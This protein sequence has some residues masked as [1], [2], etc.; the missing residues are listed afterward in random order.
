MGRR[1]TEGPIVVRDDLHAERQGERRTAEQLVAGETGAE[2]VVGGAD[3]TVQ[4]GGRTEHAQALGRTYLDAG[5]DALRARLGDIIG[6]IADRI[7]ID[8]VGQLVAEGHESPRQRTR[9]GVL[10]T[11]ADL[12]AGIAFRTQRQAEVRAIGEVVGGGR[13]VGGADLR[14]REQFLGQAMGIGNLARGLAGEIGEAVVAHGGA[15]AIDGGDLPI[16]AR[17]DAE[18]LVRVGPGQAVAGDIELL[19]GR[20]FIGEPEAEGEVRT[21]LA[22]D[23]GR[24]LVAVEE[25]TIGIRRSEARDGAAGA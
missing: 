16:R 25:V 14:M 4:P 22:V 3:L 20:A 17:P 13:A 23:E 8:Q 11:Q 15:H 18:A 12:G 5:F 1:D 10:M 24:D 9:D 6:L 21:H 19:E 2:I 7:V